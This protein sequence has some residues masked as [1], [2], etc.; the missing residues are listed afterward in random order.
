MGGDVRSI[1]RRLY[2]DADSL[3]YPQRLTAQRFRLSSQNDEDGLTLAL[4]QTADLRARRFVEI[5]CGKNGCNSGFLAQEFGWSG[6]MIDAHASR[7][8]YVQRLFGAAVVARRELVTLENVNAI[9]E[10]SGFDYDIDLLSIDIDGND[11]WC[12]RRWRRSS[13]AWSSW[14]S[15][16]C[17]APMPPWWFPTIPSSIATTWRRNI[18]SGEVFNGSYS[19]ADFRL[20][21]DRVGSVNEFSLSEGDRAFQPE[22]TEEPGTYELESGPSQMYVKWHFTAEDE[23]R[24]F[25]LRYRILSRPPRLFGQPPSRR[26]SPQQ[27]RLPAPWPSTMP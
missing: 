8:D 1:L 26:L 6:L 12:G 5:G 11:Y 10:E 27:E 3:P 24:S 16:R 9:L 4:I 15:I 13:P 2:I 20:P 22:A 23:T 19:W 17:L 7:V 21:F 14:S 18:P 25:R